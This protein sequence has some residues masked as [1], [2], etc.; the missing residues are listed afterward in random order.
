M[1][2]EAITSL[3]RAGSTIQSVQTGKFVCGKSRIVSRSLS[4]GAVRF[5]ASLGMIT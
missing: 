2:N 4:E 5:F 1:T 3:V